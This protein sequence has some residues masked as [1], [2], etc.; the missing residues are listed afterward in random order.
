MSKLYKATE[1]QGA[2]GRFHIQCDDLVGTGRNW[3]EP[4]RILGL[5]PTELIVKL[6][7]EYGAT[8]TPY[9]K[10]NK[11]NFI[12]YSWD[13]LSN[14]RRFKNYINKVARETNYQI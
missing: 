3:V 5:Q 7:S 4:A 2:S 10:D 8:I 6:K 12:G 11:V 1:F 13:N 9:R 14:A